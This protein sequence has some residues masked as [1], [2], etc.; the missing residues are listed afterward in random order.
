MLERKGLHLEP[1]ATFASVVAQTTFIKAMFGDLKAIAEL[2][3]ALEG[4]VERRGEPSE[5]SDTPIRVINFSA[6]PSHGH[7]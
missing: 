5:T 2:R 7:R 4:K 6:I 1:G 3:E